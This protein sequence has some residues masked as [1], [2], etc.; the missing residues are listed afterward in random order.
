VETDP[1]ELRGTGGVLRDL[2]QEYDDDDVLLV[3]NAAQLLVAPLH[4]LASDAAAR[5]GEVTV[6]ANSD[7][8]PSSLSLLSCR[9]LRQLPEVGFVDLKEQGLSLMASKFEVTTLW[10]SSAYGLPIRTPRDYLSALRAH[11]RMAAGASAHEEAFGERWQWTFGLAERGASVD[12]D[13][14]LHDAVVLRGGRVA[15]GAL[16]ADSIVCGGGVIRARETVVGRLSSAAGR[17]GIEPKI[18]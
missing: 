13:A 14:K 18:R 8:T 7:G 11:H 16:V 6:A 10:R 1:S 12:P 3:A 5:G 4:E 17:V 9:A 2:A 15:A